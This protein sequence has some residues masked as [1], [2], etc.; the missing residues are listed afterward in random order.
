[1][2][3]AKPEVFFPRGL[4]TDDNM[5]TSQIKNLEKAVMM[6][7]SNTDLQ[8]LYGYQLLGIGQLDQAKIPLE[9]AKRNARTAGPATSLLNLLEEVKQQSDK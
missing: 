1:M 9:V 4:Y 7:P 8:L 3:P 2:A 6:N 5:L